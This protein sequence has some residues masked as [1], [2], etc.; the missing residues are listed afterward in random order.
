MNPFDA[1]VTAV[2]LLAIV[3]GFR[4]GLL[5]SLATI[6]GYLIFDN[7]PDAWTW[8]GAG[9]II[10]SGIYIAWREQRRRVARTDVKST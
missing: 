9:L 4:S 8:V 1:F 6:L 5:R 10:A 3:M 2:A 7:F